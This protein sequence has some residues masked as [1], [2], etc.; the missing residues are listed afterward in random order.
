[1]EAALAPIMV[2]ISALQPLVEEELIT[3]KLTG[4]GFVQNTIISA[5]KR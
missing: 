3:S 2:L 5:I 4:P 1:M